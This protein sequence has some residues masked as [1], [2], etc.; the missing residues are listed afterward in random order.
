[1]ELAAVALAVAMNKADARAVVLSLAV[2]L[3]IAWPLDPEG[4]TALQWYSTLALIECAVIVAAVVCWTTASAYVAV[5]HLMLC[6]VHIFQYFTAPYAQDVSVYPV[7]VPM[8]E[9]ASLFYLCFTSKT[10]LRGYHGSV[11]TRGA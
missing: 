9:W 8:M 4:F 5:N 1:M 11:A 3:S 7:I 10:F 2:G 6:M